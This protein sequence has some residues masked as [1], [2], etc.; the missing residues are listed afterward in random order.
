MLWQDHVMMQCDMTSFHAKFARL[1]SVPSPF[2]DCLKCL[3]DLA[4]FLGRMLHSGHRCGQDALL[5]HDSIGCLSGDPLGVPILLQWR[6]VRGWIGFREGRIV[7]RESIWELRQAH[8]ISKQ[9]SVSLIVR[10]PLLQDRWPN[11]KGV[12]RAIG[13]V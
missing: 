10:W 8:N 11:L 4:P 2:A 6:L 1:I 9:F 7:T 5:R 13:I 12:I 3:Q